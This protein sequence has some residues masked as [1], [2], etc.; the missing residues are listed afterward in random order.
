MKKILLFSYDHPLLVFGI[1]GLLTVCSGFFA[2]RI[3][4]D[5]SHEALI[6]MG[7]PKTKEYDEAKKLFGSDIVAGVY[8]RDPALFTVAKLRILR[9][10]YDELVKIHGVEKTE[11][12]FTINNIR[13]EGGAIDTSPLLD[14]VPATEDEAVLKKKHAL[15]NPLIRGRLVSVNGQATIITLYLSLHSWF[16]AEIHD[17]IETALPGHDADEFKSQIDAAINAL[18]VGF[19][20][21]FKARIEAAVKK[22]LEGRDEQ[23]KSRVNAAVKTVLESH[24]DRH[25][26]AGVYHAV[27]KVLQHYGGKDRFEEAFQVG[28]PFVETSM[29]QF[30]I[31]DQIY[32][33]PLSALLLLLFIGYSLNSYL[34]AIIPISNA[35]VSTVWT[36]AVMYWLGLPINFL[37]YTIPAMM[38]VIGSLEDIHLI[39]SFMEAQKETGNPRRAVELVGQRL[40][41]IMI[42]TSFTT[43]IGF[44]ANAITDLPI[45]YAF[46]IASAIAMTFNFIA[47]IFMAPAYM[48]LLQNRL[49]PE[50]LHREGEEKNLAHRLADDLAKLVIQRLIYHPKR[51]YIALGLLL[52]PTA[53]F[54]SK[55]ELNNDLFSFFSKNSPIIVRNNILQKNLTGARIVYVQLN[56][57]VN[58]FKTSQQMQ[59][60]EKV[61][62]YLRG[63]DGFDSVTSIT[64]YLDLLNREMH[65]GDEKF[66]CVPDDDKL[67]A[68]HLLLLQRRDIERYL[69]ADYSSVNIVIRHNISSSTRFN[70]IVEQ[71]NKEL[72]RKDIYGPLNFRVTGKDVLVASGVD[73]IATGQVSSISIDVIIIVLLMAGIFLSW[74]AGLLSMIP[75]IIPIAFIFGIMGWMQIP[76]NIGTSMVAAICIGIAVDDTIHFMITYN[77]HLKNLG[78]EKAA[79]EAT[80]QGETLPVVISAFAL[81]AGFFVLGFSS[82]V[83]VAQFG[84]LSGIV[85]LMAVV[86][87][88][89]LTPILLSSV[90]LI[91]L[92]EMVGLK[93]Q[94]KVLK[95]SLLFQDMRKWQVRRLVLMSNLL[96][97]PPDY[98]VIIEG[99]EGD[100]M[101]V[102][103]DGTLAVMKNV[104]GQEQKLSQLKAGDVVGEIA[105]ICKEK[106]TASVVSETWVKLL[107]VDWNSLEKLRRW[108]PHI[109]CTFFLN[110]ARILGKRLIHTADEVQSIKSKS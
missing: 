102:V 61:T 5:V 34:A 39:A 95:T 96:E 108:L 45:L 20:D 4:M 98:R 11:S 59:I 1:I 43:I 32:L 51:I 74:R 18:P 93:L 99:N 88:L 22:A 92:W 70:A 38:I 46:G 48:R 13:N 82:F 104:N 53:W 81:A 30:L 8:V 28:S 57:D 47:T 107:A 60:A 50:T 35:L 73:S 109:S 105:L 33:L 42:C 91:T 100:C 72:S 40:G 78:S 58:A 94:E 10:I 54:T 79:L 56:K 55:I 25:F 62:A 76:L 26:Q 97:F 16:K 63:V 64:D 69:T 66:Y 49:K 2:V 67:I 103:L 6:P 101:F 44:G 15:G 21:E 24:G 110:I 85:M 89:V 41:I 86:V 17:A 84:I 9:Q 68:Q 90:R 77:Q 65:D 83:P 87:D 27:E 23:F 31:H 7:S 36:A 19:D 106:R 75:N 14:N 37:T 3:Q 12:L 80:I 71:I 29:S 52:V